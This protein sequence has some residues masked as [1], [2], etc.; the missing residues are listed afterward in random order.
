MNIVWI[1]KNGRADD[2]YYVEIA[3]GKGGV[4]AFDASRKQLE[5]IVMGI[6]EY[7]VS[8]KEVSV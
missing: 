1:E 3:L 5:G 6:T 7:L 4:V 8:G 2:K